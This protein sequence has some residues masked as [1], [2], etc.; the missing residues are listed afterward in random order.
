MR[1]DSGGD[2]Q[3]KLHKYLVYSEEYPE[4]EVVCDDG[5][6]P[7]VYGCE[8]W[9]IEAEN[10]KDALMLGVKLSLD[11]SGYA[12]DNRNEGLPPWAGFRVELNEEELPNTT[13]QV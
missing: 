10:K 3:M 9:E 5:T 4:V 11:S 12:S 7:L 1:N 2:G 6:G 8:V 13:R